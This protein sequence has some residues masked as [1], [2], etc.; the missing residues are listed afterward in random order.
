M[1]E[2]S[3]LVELSDGLC[4]TGATSAA[5]RNKVSRRCTYVVGK[6]CR[7]IELGV[8]VGL[9][10]CLVEHTASFVKLTKDLRRL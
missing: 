2:L 6:K 10:E 9:A 7:V 5:F 3:D 8:E 4:L 1:S